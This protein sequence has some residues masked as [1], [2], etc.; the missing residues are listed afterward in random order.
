[1]IIINLIVLLLQLFGLITFFEC[2][3]I[4]FGISS[5]II[6]VLNTLSVIMNFSHGFLGLTVIAIGKNIGDLVAN[7][8]LARQ[9]YQRMSFAACFGGVIFSKIIIVSIVY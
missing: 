2:V 7:V 5:E 9:G 1:M 8:S 4:I 6:S 3:L